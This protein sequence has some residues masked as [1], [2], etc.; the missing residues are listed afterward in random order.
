MYKNFNLTEEERKQILEQHSSY[1]YR[2]PLREYGDDEEYF[3]RHG[4]KQPWTGSSNKNYEKGLSDFDSDFDDETYDDFDSLNTTYPN[5]H[6]H[7]TSSGDLQH[8]KGMFDRYSR[9]IGPLQIKKR[10]IQNE[11]QTVTESSASKLAADAIS[12]AKSG[13]GSTSVAS[14]ITNCIKSNGYTHLAILTTGAGAT[15]LGALAALFVS[16]AGTIPALIIAAAGAIM[17]TIEG[18][19]TSSGSG[20]ASVTSELT[21]LHTCLKNKKVI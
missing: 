20:S 12:K 13:Q 17:V 14:E 11:E 1:G 10:R 3:A 19:L 4:D 16:G 7:Y 18:F 5:F 15:A 2:K 9:E 21:D 8:A 6:S